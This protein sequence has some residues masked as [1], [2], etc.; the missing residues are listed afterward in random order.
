M[1]S[2]SY[3]Y[4]VPDPRAWNMSKYA[5]TRA[6]GNCTAAAYL[7]PCSRPSHLMPTSSP[8]DGAG[9]HRPPASPRRAALSAARG[10]TAAA[11]EGERGGGA[12]EGVRGSVG[13]GSVGGGSVGGSGGG[14]LR[15]AER[16]DVAARVPPS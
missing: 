8:L 10:S 4:I 1:A 3:I 9:S 11:V 16:Q 14:G 13:D 7:W 12:G 2:T 15:A 5:R 6:H